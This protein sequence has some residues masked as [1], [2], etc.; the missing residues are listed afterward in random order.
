MA[1][2]LLGSVPLFSKL[3][4]T[5]RNE[6]TEMLRARQFPANQPVVW[7]GQQGDDFYVIQTGKVSV[8][9]P[10]ASGKEVILATLG[11]G[12]FFGELSFLHRGPRPDTLRT[13]NAS[14]PLS[15]GPEPFLHFH[16]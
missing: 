8:S 14:T 3:P 1:N 7:L 16:E 10:D 5:D 12:H 6:L 4:E 11:H 15:L 13:L 9:C 2:D